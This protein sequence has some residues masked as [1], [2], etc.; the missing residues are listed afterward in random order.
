MAEVR[1]YR[2]FEP[3]KNFLQKIMIHTF[4]TDMESS[5]K[6]YKKLRF[7]VYADDTNGNGGRFVRLAHPDAA[8]FLLNIRAAR[9][10]DPEIS[11]R[12]ADTRLFSI[13][14]DSYIDWA[15]HLQH[16]QIEIISWASHL[17]GVWMEVK[18]PVGNLISISTTDFYDEF[19]LVRHD[20]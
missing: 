7:E 1:D 19:E 17:W 18:D 9:S 12:P 11:L 14:V 6:F 2:K 15:A 13:V 20:L 4:A 3:N 8:G 16:E 5:I 10:S